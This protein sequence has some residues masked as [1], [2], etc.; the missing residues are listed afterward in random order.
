[1]YMYMYKYMCMHTHMHGCGFG[2]KAWDGCCYRWLRKRF[3][4]IGGFG[5]DRLSA[6]LYIYIYISG[7]PVSIVSTLS[8][9]RAFRC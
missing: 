2:N 6:Q 8:G 9:A 7:C 4:A 3:G 1:M 5:T